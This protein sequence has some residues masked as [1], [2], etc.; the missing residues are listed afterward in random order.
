MGKTLKK[1]G[2]KVR[3]EN[4]RRAVS[5][6]TK[7]VATRIDATGRPSSGRSWSLTP[8]QASLLIICVG[9]VVFCTGLTGGF[10]GDDASQIVTNTPVHSIVNLVSFFRHGTFFDG[11][12]LTGVYYR[13]MMTV[14]YS[15]LYSLFGPNPFWFHL[16]QLGFYIGGALLLYAFFRAFLKQFLALFLA[17]VFLVHPL[18]SQ[19]VFGIPSMQDVLFFFFG[20]LGLWILTRYKSNRS[21]Y[22]AA[23]CLF[24][25]LLSK[26][27]G[28]IFIVVTLAYLLLFKRARALRYAVVLVVPLSLYLL[29][30]STAVGFL[31]SDP[32]L[33]PIDKLSLL[34][35]LYTAPSLVLFYA[36]K[37]VFPWHLASAYYWTYP[38]FNARTVLLPAGIDLLTV[39]LF[40]LIGSR[41]KRKLP[42]AD[43]RAYLLFAAITVVGLA[44]YLQ[45]VPLD[46]T[47]CETW[48]Y[49]PMAGVLGMIGLGMMTVSVSLKREWLLLLGAIPISL[50]GIRTAIR[51]RDFSSEYTLAQHDVLVSAQ[52]YT[53]MNNLARALISQDKFNDAVT[54][55]QK[56]ATIY[57]TVI[58]F[59]TLGVALLDSGQYTAADTAFSNALKYGSLSIVYENQADIALAYYTPAKA[60]DFFAHALTLYPHDYKLWVYQALLD[61]QAGNN[62]GARTAIANANKYGT[63]PQALL[64]YINNNKPFTLNL[65]IARHTLIVK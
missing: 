57:P 42:K 36:Q 28:I 9:L 51:G 55:A 23:G 21:L 46:M 24:L 26:E 60:T 17:L 13:P 50:L 52:D 15:L 31:S 3:F 64:Y 39:G 12:S 58:N 34:E 18:N 6:Q 53:A 37:F 45:I 27:A 59:N 49:V 56:S 4:S 43:F 5:Q 40:V 54:Y 22:V 2:R 30:K 61:D 29:L 1:R 19:L 25:S 41:V 8:L 32:H 48:F 63:V 10:Q 65:P 7:V 11:Q 20:M 62:A 14:T 16:V 35:R 38:T 47:A 33:A 44:P